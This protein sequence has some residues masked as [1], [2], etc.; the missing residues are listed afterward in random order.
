MEHRNKV[1]IAKEIRVNFKI[2]TLS[3]ILGIISYL[4]LAIYDG[5]FRAWYLHENQLNIIIKNDTIDEHGLDKFSNEAYKLGKKNNTLVSKTYYSDST[6]LDPLRVESRL[7]K[8]QKAFKY[9]GYVYECGWDLSFNKTRVV[10]Y[11]NIET[12][13][14]TKEKVFGRYG[15]TRSICIFLIILLSVIIVRYLYFFVKWVYKYSK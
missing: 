2:L 12:L 14:N 8:A 4:T 6:Y 7:E 9:F 5:G 15:I 11:S 10:L 1:K 3:L 13:K